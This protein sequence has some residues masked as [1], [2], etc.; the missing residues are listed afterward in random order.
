MFAPIR[1]RPI[2]P[3]CIV[4]L[5]SLVASLSRCSRLLL[6]RKAQTPPVVRLG[7]PH[8]VPTFS[9]D[10]PVFLRS[11]YQNANRRIRRSNISVGRML[12]AGGVIEFEAEKNQ[13]FASRITHLGR[14]LPDPSREY[15]NVNSSQHATHRPNPVLQ[16]V[17]VDVEC[18]LCS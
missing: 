15:Q 17:N 18:Q 16:T 6:S 9:G 11:N 13:L 3:I 2:I 14:I 12:R 4:N 5:L 8:E 7:R 10:R 1:P